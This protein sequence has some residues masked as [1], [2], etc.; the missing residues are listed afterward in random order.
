M[1]LY[2][3]PKEAHYL[4]G[5]EGKQGR[6]RAEK[7]HDTSRAGAKQGRQQQRRGGGD[8]SQTK[9]TG[10]K[11]GA[12]GRG[13]DGGRRAAGGGRTD[14]RTGGLTDGRCPRGRPVPNEQRPRVGGTFP[15]ECPG[16]P[17]RVRHPAPPLPNSKRRNANPRRTAKEHKHCHG[18]GQPE[19]G[20]PQRA[21][22]PRHSG[23]FRH[24]QLAAHC[25]T[26]ATQAS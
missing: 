6:G 16:H 21:P 20:T 25:C 14:G 4:E 23:S 22:N 11:A 2:K 3:W 5:Q 12:G 8:P 24:C 1:L 17:A 7:G 15:A 13:A 19:P 9:P 26:V 10:G 18:R